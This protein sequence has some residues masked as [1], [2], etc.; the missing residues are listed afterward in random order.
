MKKKFVRLEFYETYY[1]A[2]ILS[3]IISD[4]FPYIRGI[5]EWYEDNEESVF[6]PS[7]PKFS[8]LHSFSVHII[9]S[10]IAE[11]VNDVEV[12]YFAQK[13]ANDV[14]VDRALKF[15]G[16]PCDGFQDYL[17]N[18]GVSTA[19]LNEDHLYDYHQ[20][21]MLT[22]ELDTLLEHLADEVF[23]VLFA[24]R[25]LL[26][27]FN[28]FMARG[29]QLFF[30]EVPDTELGSKLKKPGVLKRVRIPMWVKKA[31]FFRDR[32]ICSQ[33]NK[34]ISGQFSSQPDAQYDHII[35][36]A[37][38]GLNDVTNIQLLCQK[39][40]GSKSKAFVPVSTIYESWY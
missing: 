6:L 34:D 2:N 37:M 28:E 18:A 30:D 23:H 27:Q 24:N 38:G 7:F 40:N 10:L 5:H 8:R 16:L 19:D 26:A 31:V 36:L 22:G 33:C 32:G 11:Q 1:Y 12:D 14:W 21:L 15:H 20:E 39:C 29:L 13:K 9:D 4:P 17:D 35:P 3:N 25:K